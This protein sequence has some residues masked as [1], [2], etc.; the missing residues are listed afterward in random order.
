M[1]WSDGRR[2]DNVEDRR[3]MTVGRKAVGGGIGTIIL[4][5]VAMYFG[6]DPSVVLQQGGSPL[7]APTET[8]QAGKPP[9]S[10]ELAQFVSVVL[11]DTEDTWHELFRKNGKTYQEPKLVLFTGAVESACGYAQAAMGP[12][13]CPLDQKVYIDLSFYRDL[14]ERFKAPGDFAQAYVIAHEVGHHVQS[15]LGISEKA[16]DLQQRSGKT[17]A[18]QL[19][20]RL[21][22]QADCL[23]GIWAHHADRS[24]QVLESG[25]VEEALQAATSIGDDRLQQQAQGYVVPESF[26]HGSSEQ[27]VRWFKTGLDTGNFGACNTFGAQSL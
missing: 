3:G 21:E 24:R 17:Q 19:S 4:A 10:D 14:K 12:F 2:S 15:L 25:D 11:A 7:T 9:A 22:L 13:Y 20:V 6:I 16:H 1:R 26:T 8:R 18:N 23:A 27:R 5:L